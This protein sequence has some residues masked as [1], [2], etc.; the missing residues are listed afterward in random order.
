MVSEDRKGVEEKAAEEKAV[1]EKGIERKTEEKAFE[2]KKQ[3]LLDLIEQDVRTDCVVAFSGGV[4][5]SLLL[6]LACLQAK[7]RRTVVYGV[8]ICSELAPA[9]D[10]KNAASVA[11][12]VGAEFA[13]LQIQE[14]SQSSIAENR[15]DRCY[16]CKKY[17]F[18]NL[19]TFAKEHGTDIVLEG[20]NEDDL[21]AYRPGIQAIHELGIQSPLAQAGFTKKDVRQLAA[22][23]GLSVA[24]RP[25][26]PCMATR[27]P[28][29]THL[30][31]SSLERVRQGEELLKQM[32]FYNIR[33]RVYDNL[34]R[35]EVDENDLGKAVQLRRELIKGI[36][37]L[38]YTYVTLDLEGFRSGSMDIR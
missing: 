31:L 15:K 6:K 36:K 34:A 28:Y 19:R 23:Y 7:K 13:V 8:L 26:S 11:K 33:L 10:Q 32:G 38:G 37:S 3:T 27:F 25:S 30:T 24:D 5:S 2:E 22:D 12:E 17:L 14:L 1:V 29:G 16:V 18:E 21:H 9:G 35:I 4:D 20:T